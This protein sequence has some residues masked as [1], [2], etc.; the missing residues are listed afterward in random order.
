MPIGNISEVWIERTYTPSVIHVFVYRRLHGQ[1]KLYIVVTIDN[2]LACNVPLVSDVLTPCCISQGSNI[3]PSKVWREMWQTFCCKF[4]AVYIHIQ[5]S[6]IYARLLSRLKH[7][8]L[9]V[10]IMKHSKLSVGQ[11][12]K[13]WKW[14]RYDGISVGNGV[15]VRLV[16]V[17]REGKEGDTKTCFSAGRA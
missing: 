17:W 13:W 15:V 8:R 2:L 10:V 1:N 14:K 5:F 11:S 16:G 3:G 4:C 12:V 7:C 6:T 9:L